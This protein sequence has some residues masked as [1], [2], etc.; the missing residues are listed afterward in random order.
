[1]ASG[2]TPANQNRDGELQDHLRHCPE[3]HAWLQAEMTL[4]RDLN[5]AATDDASDGIPLAALRTRVESHVRDA[6]NKRIWETSSM[7]KFANKL[8][9]RPRLGTTLGIVAVLLLIA[10]L[11]PLRVDQTVGYEVAL[12]GVNK[13][14]AMDSEKITLLLNT[15]GVGDADVTLGECE[16]TCKL[17]ISELQS[18]GDVKLVVA[19]FDELGNCVL[20]NVIELTEPGSVSIYS[21]AK[22]QFRDQK[23]IF[24]YA[25]ISIDDKAHNKGR[26]PWKSICCSR[27]WCRMQPREQIDREH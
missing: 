17:T 5:A 19:A 2:A 27:C 16:A 7:S 15:L 26:N 6:V 13:D 25:S 8:K 20:E 18:E 10:T 9:S 22:I 1:M 14:L 4:H 23:A 11:V 21:A 12:A 24:D 3:C